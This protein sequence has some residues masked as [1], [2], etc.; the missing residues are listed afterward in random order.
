MVWWKLGFFYCLVILL[1]SIFSMILKDKNVSIENWKNKTS[2]IFKN[3]VVIFGSGKIL[4][5]GVF[6]YFI[7][8][9][10][11]IGSYKTLLMLVFWWILISIDIHKIL[12]KLNIKNEKPK[13]SIGEIF[14]VQSKKIFLVKLFDDRKQDIVKFDSVVF[15]YSMNDDSSIIFRGMVFDT[16]LLNN[17][18]WA[19]IL[20]LKSF[21]DQKSKL[22]KNI[23]Y[24]EKEREEISNIINRFVGVVMEDSSIGSIKFEYSKKGS[25]IKE[26]DM[27]EVENS[28]GVIIFFQVIN[29]TTEK[30][31]LEE[32]NET[33]YI[34]GEAVQ[35]G[36]WNQEKCSFEKYGWVIPINSIV[37]RSD[38]SNIVIPKIIYPEYALG[39]IPS[40]TLPAIL[41]IDDISTHHIAILGVTGAGKSVVAREIIKEMIN[42]EKKVIC[43]D[44]TGEYLEK[45]SSLS[46]V[47]IIHDKS[48]IDEVETAIAAKETAT[49]SKNSADVLRYKKLIQEKIY[50]YIK[51]FIESDNNLGLFELPDL[52]NTTFI[53]EFTQMFLDSVFQYAKKNPGS[54]ICIVI[55]EAHTVIPEQS[56]LGELGDYSNNK[57][58]VSKVGQIALQGRKYGVG[59]VII[60]QRTANVSKTVLTQ[61]NTV[62]CFQAFDE[63]SFNFLGNYIGKD[64]VKTLPNLLPYHAIIAG[65]AVKSNVPMIVDFTIPNYDNN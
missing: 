45:L 51:E 11:S 48:G 15:K 35:L 46:P 4:F 2:D 28:D 64:L 49:K 38:T 17:E 41:N 29:G 58:I 10:Y 42:N 23:V 40:T 47:A 43:V 19:K 36:I 7:F 59:F 12:N 5:S 31:V 63:T 20:Y 3:I 55:E 37:L 54:K 62:I 57:A 8:T 61:C 16:Y 18:K 25:N 39:V 34:R 60:A 32:K 30:R 44:F 9:N 24:K 53:L 14:G 56:S 13:E 26:G 52:S 6:L 33:D 22:E 65:K 1:L 50:Q 21:N 27:L